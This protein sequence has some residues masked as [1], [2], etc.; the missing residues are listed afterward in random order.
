MAKDEK[1]RLTVYQLWGTSFFLLRLNRRRNQR[2][3]SPR[4]FEMTG[5]RLEKVGQE[6]GDRKYQVPKNADSAYKIFLS[7]SFCQNF[8]SP[9]FHGRVSTIRTTNN[10][11]ASFGLSLDKKRV[12]HPDW[13]KGLDSH[14]KFA[15]HQF[16][17]RWAERRL[18]SD[19]Q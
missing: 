13:T 11:V 1:R 14:V 6:N 15:P 8:Y 9:S 5:P 12:R 18:R 3:N 7:T 17:F 19:L 4:R 16:R 10:R 2:L